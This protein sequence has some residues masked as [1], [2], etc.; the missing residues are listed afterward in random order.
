MEPVR[1]DTAGRGVP[2]APE[3]VPERRVENPG[4]GS[5]VSVTEMKRVAREEAEAGRLGV[6]LDLYRKAI[7]ATE[8]HGRP[9]DPLLHVRMGDIHHRLGHERM[10]VAAYG[11]AADGYRSDER[12]ANAVAVWKRVLRMFP[13]HVWVHRELADLH[14]E[15]DLVA[16]ARRHALAYVEAADERGEP[17]LAVEVLEAFLELE[18]DDEVAA[19]LRAYRALQREKMLVRDEAEVDGATAPS[20]EIAPPAPEPSRPRLGR[21]ARLRLPLRPE[22]AT[23]RA[24]G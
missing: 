24:A 16:E 23:L 6:A 22:P 4:P 15:Q 7:E 13:E 17:G 2:S 8:H 21:R 1:P 11:R 20:A 19:V 18:D 9:P 12:A 14:L 5:T 10:A 3:P